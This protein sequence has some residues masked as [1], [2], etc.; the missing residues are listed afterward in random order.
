[1]TTTTNDTNAWAEKRFGLE[2]G[3]VIGYNGGS[4]YNKVWVRSMISARKVEKA[5]KGKTC[6]GGWFHGMEKGGIS[7]R[8]DGAFEV[9]C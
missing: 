6:N 2:A 5:M 9:I 3:D 4:A 7:R 8:S 1:M